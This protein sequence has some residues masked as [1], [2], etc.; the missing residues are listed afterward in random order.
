M[1]LHSNP[2]KRLTDVRSQVTALREGLRVLDEQIAYQQGVA[3]DAAVDAVVQGP[4]AAREQRAAD[5]DV[6]RTRR[7]R[8]RTAARLAGLIAEQD[9]LLERLL[10]E[11]GQGARS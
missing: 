4:L 8:D 10:D 3:D 7:E 11:A 2:Q 5:G 6:Q 1:R 9:S